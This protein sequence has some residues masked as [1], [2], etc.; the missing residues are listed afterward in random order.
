M[1]NGIKISSIQVVHFTL[2]PSHRPYAAHN[3]I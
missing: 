2:R 1:A 3:H